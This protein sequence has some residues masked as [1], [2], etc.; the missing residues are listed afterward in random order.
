MKV[1]LVVP[2]YNPG[3]MWQRWVNS[4]NT[5]SVCPNLVVQIDSNSADGNVALS[6]LNGFHVDFVSPDE[7]N[8]GGTRNYAVSKVG[9]SDVIVFL[10]QDAILSSPDSLSNLLSWFL[11]PHVSAVYGRQLPH[12]NANPLSIHARLF[13][14]PSKSDVRSIEDCDRLGVKVAFMSNSFSAYRTSVFREVGGFPENTI[15]AEDMYITAKMLLAGYKI[16]YAAN[17][18]VYHSHNYSP[19]EEFKRY[20]DIGVFHACEPWIQNELGKAASEGNRFVKSEM[21]YLLKNSPLWIPRACITTIFKF[22]G[23]KLGLRYQSIPRVVRAKLSMYKSYWF[24][25]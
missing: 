23:Y 3:N 18:T 17:A 12:S 6:R 11:D 10:T 20:F 14:Y 24:Q 2:T 13:N 16:V 4:L 1:A 19:W 7:F 22:L 21:V 15:L 25:Q 8:H 5:Q 9:D